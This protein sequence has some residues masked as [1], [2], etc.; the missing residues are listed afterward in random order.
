[1]R[2]LEDNKMRLFDYYYDYDFGYDF[3]AIIGNSPRLNL[4]QLEL[5]IT[6]FW[7][8]EPDIRLTFEFLAG[9]VFG[10]RLTLWSMSLDVD[11][12]N[13]RYPMDLNHTRE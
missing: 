10:M 5:H 13:Y 4:L 3:Y 6:E 2:L 12:L 1:M 7:S 9:K 11:I 8:W